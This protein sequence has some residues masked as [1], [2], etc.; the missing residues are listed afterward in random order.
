MEEGPN[1][2]TAPG[3]TTVLM[4]FYG[5]KGRPIV[6]LRIPQQ[7]VRAPSDKVQNNIGFA[8]WV[9]YPDLKGAFA[10]GNE[11][12]FGCVGYCRG[13]M[14]IE[15]MNRSGVLKDAGAT[16]S[17]MMN[18][19]HC[20]TDSS[21]GNKGFKRAEH[22]AG[23]PKFP[24]MAEDFY[25]EEGAQGGVEGFVICHPLTPNPMC[26]EWMRLPKNENVEVHYWFSLRDLPHWPALRLSVAN[27]VDSFVV[28]TLPPQPA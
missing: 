1:V 27:L 20:I 11:G 24:Q 19:K 26:E 15:L 6:W 2:N 4:H 16:L 5:A 3:T 9:T 18:F 10:D 8:F 22:C 28:K 23:G 12:L 7:Y 25:I 21:P 14:M 13:R 17:L